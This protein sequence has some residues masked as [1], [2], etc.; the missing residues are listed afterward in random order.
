MVSPCKDCDIANPP[1]C[2]NNCKKLKGFQALLEDI[3]QSSGTGWCA[4]TSKRCAPC[5]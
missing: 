5:E 3:P 1:K 4:G 2:R